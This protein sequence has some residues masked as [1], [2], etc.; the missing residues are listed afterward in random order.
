MNA[1]RRPTQDTGTIT[2]PR[3]RLIGSMRG[4]VPL[5]LFISNR[6]PAVTFLGKPGHAWKNCTA[7]SIWSLHVISLT[8]IGSCKCEWWLWCQSLTFQFFLLCDMFFFC[9]F[10]SCVRW[11][12]FLVSAFLL[13]L[14][15]SL[16]LNYLMSH[17]ELVQTWLILTALDHRRLGAIALNH[18]GKFMLLVQN[19]HSSGD[20]VDLWTRQFCT[21]RTC[22]ALSL[23]LSGQQTSRDLIWWDAWW[24]RPNPWCRPIGHI[25]SFHQPLHRQFQPL[26]HTFHLHAKPLHLAH[27]RCHVH[28]HNRALQ[29][30]LPSL[31]TTSTWDTFFD[32]TNRPSP[33]WGDQNLWVWLKPSLAGRQGS[34]RQSE[35]QWIDLPSNHSSVSF[36]SKARHWRVWSFGSTVGGLD[37]STGQQLLASQTCSWSWSLPDPYGGV[38]VVGFPCWPVICPIGVMIV[39]PGFFD[40][41]SFLFFGGLWRAR[42]C[43]LSDI[44][45]WR[46]LLKLFSSFVLSV[47]FSFARPWR[48]SFERIL[49]GHSFLDF[50]AFSFSPES[51]VLSCWSFSHAA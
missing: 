36:H 43:L 16:T 20:G 15:K 35:D 10:C 2:I 14:Q 49:A 31:R 46:L 12:T 40:L 6:K 11:F 48:H 39:T 25:I 44:C 41:G 38:S 37:V 50:F 17:F 19:Y 18:V 34:L 24:I 47:A 4:F 9:S 5:D 33:P 29:A 45:F 42:W 8:S 27:R 1:L 3:P 26:C 21:F 23:D 32:I 22:R 13:L 28:Q 7:V 30:H 51:C